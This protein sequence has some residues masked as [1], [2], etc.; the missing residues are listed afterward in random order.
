MKVHVHAHHF[1]DDPVCAWV[2]I[3]SILALT[4]LASLCL[5]LDKGY[6]PTTARPKKTRH[7][8]NASYYAGLWRIQGNSGV[9]PSLI[10][11]KMEHCQYNGLTKSIKGDVKRNVDEFQ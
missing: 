7:N 2:C 3:V 8:D 9:H 4:K 1:L 6:L 5:E 10:A 11:L